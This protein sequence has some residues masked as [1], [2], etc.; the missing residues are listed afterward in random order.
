MRKTRPNSVAAGGRNDGVACHGV[1]DERTETWAPRASMSLIMVERR[2]DLVDH[3]SRG[4]DDEL[5]VRAEERW[6]QRSS[7]QLFRCSGVV[8]SETPSFAKTVAGGVNVDGSRPSLAGYCKGAA[9]AGRGG[10]EGSAEGAIAAQPT[11]AFASLPAIARGGN[12]KAILALSA[13]A[14]MQTAARVAA[15]TRREYLFERRLSP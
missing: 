1:H 6:N 4:D 9:F 15:I 8:L 3:P 13:K 14:A 7:L 12:A 11:V 2:D 10:C 5:E